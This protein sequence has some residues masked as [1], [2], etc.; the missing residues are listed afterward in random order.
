RFGGDPRVVGQSLTLNGHGYT[1]VGVMPAGFAGPKFTGGDFEQAELWAPF[2]P[3]LG[4]WT[5]DGR[6]VDAAIARLKPGVTLEQAQAEMDAIAAQLREQHPDTNAGAGAA[7]ASLHEQAV[8][9]IRPALLTFLAAVG[10]VLLIACANV[11]NLLLAR[12]AARQKEMAVRMAL[13]AGRL[14]IVRQ[15]LTES[16]LLASL[17]GAAGLLLALWA[18][19][20]LAALGSGAIP[21]PDEIG[22]DSRVLLF[23]LGVSLLTGVAFGLAPALAASRPN[24]HEMLKEGGRCQTGGA[25]RKRLRSFLVVS[26]VALSLLLLVGAGLLVKSFVRLQQVNPGFDPRNVL[27]M[28]AFLPGAR[29]PEEWQHADF[30]EKVLERA[31]QLPGVEAAGVVSNLPVSGNF[32]RIGLYVEGHEAAGREDIPDPERYMV[33]AGYFKAMRIPLL[34]GRAFGPQDTAEA[35][36]VVIV[37]EGLARRFWPEGGALGKRIRTDP[38]RPWMTVVGVVG[39]VR[40]YGLETAPTMQLYLPHRQVPSQVMTLVVRCA[41]DPAALAAA[42]REQVWAVDKDQPVYNVRTMEQLLGESLAQRRFTMLLVAVFA[43]AALLLAAVGLYG[44]MSYAVAQ[45]THEIGIRMALGA[46]RRDVLR[47]MLGQGMSLTLAGVCLGLAAAAGLTRV[48]ASLLYGVSATDPSVYAGVTLI[49][50]AVAFLAS[51]IPARKATR[52]DPVIALRYE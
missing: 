43:G 26:E 10:L 8:G 45:R 31:R 14:R 2:A 37:N 38:S 28:Y 50:T 17:G 29:Y 18:T 23:T 36:P 39:E 12:A 13:G 35:P 27:T 4:Q 20:L 16:V 3:D 40:H 34:G 5:R 42:V 33:D 32:D 11:A 22:L 51:S 7:V 25:G 30:F 19:N 15:L 6:S 47:I 46:Q 41:G 48:L 21:R 44:V 24:L 1:V 52:V 49:L 9:G